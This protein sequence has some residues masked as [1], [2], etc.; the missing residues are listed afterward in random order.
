MRIFLLLFLILFLNLD[1]KKP[2]FASVCA[3][4]QNEAPYLKE[5]IE[6]HQLLGFEHFY[7]YNNH[8]TDNFKDVL[9]PYIK[10]GV[11]ELIDWDYQYDQNFDPVQKA[12]YNHC[13]LVSKDKTTWL[14]VIDIDEFIV[15]VQASTIQEFLAPY[16]KKENVGGILIFWVFYGTSYLPQ[17]PDGKLLIESLTLRTQLDNSWN[18]NCKSICK[19][20]KVKYYHVH[21]AEYKSGS[22]DYATNAKHGMQPP[23]LDQI[24]INH[25]WTRAEDFLYN[26]KAPRRAKFTGQPWSQSDL[27]FIIE[28]GNQI[29]DGAIL[30]FVPQ[31]RKK[32]NLPTQ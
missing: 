8:S 21:G 10:K 11:V 29:E 18:F 15:P 26:V 17:I 22:W 14:A 19:P 5:W 24:R 28:Q 7:L 2:Y 32:M 23:V 16:N 20:N 12:A 25:Y 3:I 4:F 13:I 30:K 27:D 6:Y 1:A 31:L 9:Q